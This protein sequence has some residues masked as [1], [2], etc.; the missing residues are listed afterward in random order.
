MDKSWVPPGV[1][2]GIQSNMSEASP[3]KEAPL[4]ALG[5]NPHS[6]RDNM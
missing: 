1:T 6:I 3:V 4:E 5:R 2:L